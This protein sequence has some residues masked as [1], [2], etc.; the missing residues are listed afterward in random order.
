MPYSAACLEVFAQF[1]SFD[2]AP[3]RADRDMRK[4]TAIEG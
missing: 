4:K 2:S 1:G 3:M